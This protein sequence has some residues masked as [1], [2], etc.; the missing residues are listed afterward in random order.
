MSS[1]RSDNNLLNQLTKLK[2]L[3]KSNSTN[4][5]NLSNNEFSLILKSICTSENAISYDNID[6]SYFIWLCIVHYNVR[7]AISIK[8]SLIN[9]ET[10]LS[11]EYDIYIKS[12]YPLAIHF[13]ILAKYPYKTWHPSMFTYFEPISELG[14]LVPGAIVSWAFN[15]FVY[16][17]NSKF[18]LDIGDTGHVGCV[19]SNIKNNIFN[20]CHSIP[21]KDDFSKG[22]GGPSETT[23]NLKSNKMNDITT[24]M[25][26][27]GAFKFKEAK[28]V[29]YDFI[30]PS[31][32]IT[33]F[34]KEK[35]SGRD[36]LYKIRHGAL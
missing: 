3:F 15:S 17:Q 36:I 24:G 34:Q 9:V 6:C 20:L 14:Y 4:I 35:D 32:T 31:E 21:K 16:N 22:T 25:V 12:D 11:K 7:A 18:T 26:I 13:A 23:F 1:S 10:Y 27:G 28:Y 33:N 2:S 30:N 5:N 8:N 19:S 29:P